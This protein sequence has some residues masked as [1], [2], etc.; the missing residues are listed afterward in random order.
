VKRT[1]LLALLTAATA[2]AAPIAK[3]PPWI[4][5][6]S[7][8]NPYDPA[9]RGAV[10]VVHASFREGD[11]Q[12]SDLTGTAE[13]LVNGARRSIPLRFEATGRTNQ[14]SLK[15]Q[16]PSDGVWLAKINLKTTTAIV[17]FDEAGKVAGVSLPTHVVNGSDVVPR[18]VSN[19]DV[20][21]TLARLAR[22]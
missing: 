6:E 17:T 13:G 18:A 9:T 1:A 22:H 3:W 15:K 5:I 21:S 4:S 7:P 8:V 19:R 2:F 20:D 10:L 12:L 11:A 16:W 14:F